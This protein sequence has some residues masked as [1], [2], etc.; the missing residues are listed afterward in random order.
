MR[1]AIGCCGP[2]VLE[3][4]VGV[5]PRVAYSLRAGRDISA[6]QSNV[7]ALVEAGNGAAAL[8][9]MNDGLERAPAGSYVELDLR[10]RLGTALSHEGEYRRAAA[11]LTAAGDG[12]RANGMS[13]STEASPGVRL[14][15][16]VRL[17]RTGRH[18]SR[19]RSAAVLRPP[20]RPRRREAAGHAVRDHTV[21][22]HRGPARRSA[23]RTPRPPPRVRATLRAWIRARPESG[24][25]SRQVAA[26]RCAVT[27]QSATRRLFLR[28]QQRYPSA[29]CNLAAAQA[30]RADLY[31]SRLTLDGESH[32]M[33]DSS[34]A[35]RPDAKGLVID[36]LT[37]L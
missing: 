26:S 13:P 9:L 37:R 16:R 33:R 17:R 14:P 30:P 5:A 3:R 21:A 7:A 18:R 4:E 27:A 29:S 12:F 35:E 20:R 36:P 8:R 11:L 22:R 1:A 10:N 2:S 23:R 25:A 28:A 31:P 19:A 15:A 6:C 24:P 34:G 32:Q